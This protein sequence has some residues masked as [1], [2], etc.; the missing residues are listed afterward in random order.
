MSANTG[1]VDCHVPSV[2]KPCSIWYK[3][4]GCWPPKTRPLLILHGGPGF[5]HD[6]LS[7]LE[8][9]TSP[10]WNLSL[11]FFD[12]LGS[13]KSTHLPEKYLDRGFW[14]EQLFLDQVT[15]VIRHLNVQDDYNMLGH[16]WGGM[17]ASSYAAKNPQGLKNLVL[18]NTPVSGGH[19]LSVYKKYRD[20]MP[21]PHR[22]ILE[23]PRTL[24]TC[25]DDAYLSA[26]EEFNRRHFIQMRILPPDLLKSYEDMASDRTVTVST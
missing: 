12:Q 7:S 21:K 6:Y 9:L 16:S 3:I 22:E 11:I 10:P 2:A 25:S 4:S 5:T 15:A 17:L 20:S 23:M 14:T 8:D 13:G 19:W 26:M 1:F 24:S 18:A